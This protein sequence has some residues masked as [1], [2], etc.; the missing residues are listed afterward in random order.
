MTLSA[1]GEVRCIA[2]LHLNAL[3]PRASKW[4]YSERSHLHGLLVLLFLE[5]KR[6]SASGL[7]G[8]ICNLFFLRGRAD[9][10]RNGPRDTRDMRLK[11]DWRK[12]RVGA[13]AS[14]AAGPKLRCCIS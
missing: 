12:L 11:S 3:R 14:L 9:L 2:L 7:S 13:I 4:G 10:S 1:L 6:L 5:P 8:N